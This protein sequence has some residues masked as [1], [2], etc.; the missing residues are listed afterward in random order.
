VVQ[1][2]LITEPVDSR[3]FGE[4]SKWGWGALAFI[5]IIPYAGQE[6]TPEHHWRHV[7]NRP[8]YMFVEDL[9]KTIESDLQASGIAT[10]VTYVKKL[11][12]AT[13]DPQ[14]VVMDVDVTE[15]ASSKRVPSRT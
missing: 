15:E 11:D 14:A 1:K 5:P 10:N 9:A 12:K 2:L 4:R 13:L 8:G 3:P 6:I 7:R